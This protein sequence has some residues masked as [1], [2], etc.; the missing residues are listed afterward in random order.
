MAACEKGVNPVQVSNN[1]R[2]TADTA[3]S[4]TG[5]SLVETYRFISLCGI[6]QYQVGSYAI[7][8]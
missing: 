4:V 7:R 5:G 1:I 2:L 8:Q 3:E 6:L